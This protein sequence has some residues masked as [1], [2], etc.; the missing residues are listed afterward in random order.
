MRPRLNQCQ[1]YTLRFNYYCAAEVVRNR[2]LS[3]QPV[4]NWLKQHHSRLHAEVLS[5]TRREIDCEADEVGQ[6]A[7]E[8]FDSREVATMLLISP[9]Q[10]QRLAGELGGRLV[11]GRWVFNRSAI[12][13][14]SERRNRA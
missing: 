14:F 7:H 12:E 9:R 6:S 4:P 3:G 5:C 1:S 11:G 10:V 13:A 8:W 2:Q